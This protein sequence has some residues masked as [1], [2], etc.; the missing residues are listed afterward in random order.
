MAGINSIENK[1]E[2]RIVISA[3]PKRDHQDTIRESGHI[4]YKK[5][6]SLVVPGAAILILGLFFFYI[7]NYI[8][9]KA[10]RGLGIMVG[11]LMMRIC[12]E[13]AISKKRRLPIDIGLTNYKQQLTTYYKTRKYIHLILSPLLLA[14]YIYGFAMLLSIFKQELMGEFY[15]YIIYVSGAV[16]FGLVVL[17]VLQL[18]RELEILKLLLADNLFS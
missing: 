13:F 5:W 12:I 16:F 2:Q 8:S 3:Q 4:R 1:G 18:R 10:I 6:I 9:S 7:S 11:P 15:V 14:S 17:I